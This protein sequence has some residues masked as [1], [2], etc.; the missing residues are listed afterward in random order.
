M[1]FLRKS[2]QPA[3]AACSSE[4]RRILRLKGFRSLTLRI[5]LLFAASFFLGR[6]A[7]L[8]VLYVRHIGFLNQVDAC[9]FRCL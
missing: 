7:R 4:N 2:T 9:K 8:S 3:D 5:T 6:S 1:R